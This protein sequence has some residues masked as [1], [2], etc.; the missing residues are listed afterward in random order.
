MIM[1]HHLLMNI[2]DSTK[3]WAQ[4]APL[5]CRRDKNKRG[6]LAAGIATE[7]RTTEWNEAAKW[8]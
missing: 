6:K 3:G 1:R 2:H 5:Y 8:Q 4:A 7:H